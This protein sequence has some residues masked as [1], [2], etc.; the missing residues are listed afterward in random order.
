MINSKTLLIALASLALFACGEAD[1]SQ[2]LPPPS[3]IESSP[4]TIP[5]SLLNGY[6]ANAIVWI[7]YKQNGALDSTEPFAFSDNQGFVSFN[8]NTGKNYCS[9]QLAS[10]RAFCL[11]TGVSAERYTIKAAKGVEVLSGERFKSVLTTT[12]ELHTANQFMQQ[13][14]SLPPRPTGDA[15]DWLATVDANIAKLSIFTS[16]ASYLV[17]SQSLVDVLRANNAELPINLTDQALLQYNYLARLAESDGL[18]TT[19]IELET[20]LGRLSEYLALNLDAASENLDMGLDGLPISHADLVVKAMTAVLSGNQSS[21]QSVTAFTNYK[22]KNSINSDFIA[23]LLEAIANDASA[24]VSGTIAG[25]LSDT[26]LASTSEQLVSIAQIYFDQA[27][28][29][30]DIITA[31]QMTALVTLATPIVKS[32]RAQINALQALMNVLV[33]PTNPLAEKLAQQSSVLLQQLQ[34]E[35]VASLQHDLQSLANNLINTIV[36]EGAQNSSQ[37]VA[38][39]PLSTLAQVD[40]QTFAFAGHH[41]SLSGVYDDNEY[42]Q[43]IAFFN[44]AE[45]DQSGE[46]IMCVAYRNPLDPSEDIIGER[47][48][49][50]WSEVGSRTRLSLVA[51]GIT[52]QMKLFGEI[53]GAAIPSENQLPQFEKLA[54]ELYGEF[55]FRLNEREDNWYSDSPSVNQSFGLSANQDVPQ[56]SQ[57]CASRLAI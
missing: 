41:L 57:Q 14:S 3:E 51:E 11:Q 56:T 52:V 17:Q 24:P 27:L 54:G 22:G 37:V 29:S 36:R 38:D 53:D 12:I 34:T 10:E 1:Q 26:V 55:S 6:V 4:V 42:G 46:L 45:S 13:L 30:Q 31:Q 5:L 35:Q 18:A 9:S 28:S 20:T 7:D 39:A 25:V 50:S 8:P 44:G 32:D 21:T 19:L 2:D 48:V 16:M 23:T 43:V 40:A 33:D 15:S 49:G 47:F